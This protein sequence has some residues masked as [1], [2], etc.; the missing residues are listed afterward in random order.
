VG[1]VT[2]K[3]YAPGVEAAYTNA[4][5]TVRGVQPMTL[6]EIFVANVMHNRRE[7]R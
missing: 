7:Q 3:T 2:V 5:I 4:G 1:V 6:E